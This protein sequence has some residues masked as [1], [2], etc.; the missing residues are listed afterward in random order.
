MRGGLAVFLVKEHKSPDPSL[1]DQ[2]VDLNRIVKRIFLRNKGLEKSEEGL[3]PWV[4]LLVFTASG[5]LGEDSDEVRTLTLRS[6]WI[7]SLC[8][9]LCLSLRL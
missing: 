3:E 5:D 4:L 2:D 7:F 8:A 6:G 9:L 1:C